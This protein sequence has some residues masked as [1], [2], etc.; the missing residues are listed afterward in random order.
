[1]DAGLSLAVSVT[2][3]VVIFNRLSKQKPYRDGRAVV[4]SCKIGALYLEKI[5]KMPRSQLT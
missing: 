4:F 2:A 3:S 1:M 5:Q